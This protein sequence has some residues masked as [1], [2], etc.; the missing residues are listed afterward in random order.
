[1]QPLQFRSRSINSWLIGERLVGRIHL[2]IA[3]GR[4]AYEL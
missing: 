2:T 1:M 3:D 4:T